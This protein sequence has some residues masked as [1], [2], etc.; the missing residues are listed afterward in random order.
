MLV[1]IK[2]KEPEKIN[3]TV[4]PYKIADETVTG[5]VSENVSYVTLNRRASVLKRGEVKGTNFSIWA[6]GIVTETD[7]YTIV[8]YTFSGE[9]KEIPLVVNI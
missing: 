4:N 7:N 8:V 6:Q 5:T 9:T 1:T 3:L 2:E